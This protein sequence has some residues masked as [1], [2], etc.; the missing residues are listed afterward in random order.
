ME[1]AWF[2]FL[3]SKI[4]YCNSF[5][6]PDLQKGSRVSI[7]TLENRLLQLFHELR[8][9]L[10]IFLVSIPTLENRLLQLTRKRSQ[11][12]APIRFNSYPRKSLIATKPPPVPE[13]QQY[14]FQ[15]L[16]SKIAYCNHIDLPSASEHTSFNSYP[17][18]SLI[19]TQNAEIGVIAGIRFQFLPSKIAYCNGKNRKSDR[20]FPVVS[21]PTLENR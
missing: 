10:L 17:R 20:L 18:K 6:L 3:P 14:R 15:F 4:A 9:P 1:T 2:Q 13:N 8:R 19:A 11:Y 12:I 5:S 7:P 21:I 16:P